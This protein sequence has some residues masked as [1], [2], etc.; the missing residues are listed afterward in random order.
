MLPLTTKLDARGLSRSIKTFAALFG[1]E[2]ST[3]V[4]E[5]MFYI[6]IRARNATGKATAA[7]I[8][9]ELNHRDQRGNT[10]AENLVVSKAREDGGLVTNVKA[11][12]R[13]LISARVRSISYHKSALI[14]SI[15]KAGAAIGRSRRTSQKFASPPGTGK[16][17]RN[18]L[19]PTAVI[20][21]NAEGWDK[22]NPQVLETAV[23]GQMRFFERAIER[24]LKRNAQRAGFLTTGR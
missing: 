7:Q 21:I 3:L 24:K 13:K 12:A 15:Q 14:P 6:A 17:A 22:Q 18:T 11:E 10:L 16:V 9:G 23:Q 20:E 5:A 1:R 2:E 19:K 4:N 8:R